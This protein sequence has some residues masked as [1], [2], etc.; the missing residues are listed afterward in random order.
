V[1]QSSQEISLDAHNPVFY[2]T[3]QKQVDFDREMSPPQKRKIQRGNSYGEHKVI[4]PGYVETFA[5]KKAQFEKDLLQKQ[6]HVEQD[7]KD[8]NNYGTHY[9][10]QPPLYPDNQVISHYSDYESAP[11]EFKSYPQQSSWESKETEKNQN[12][13]YDN[14]SKSISPAKEDNP[15]LLKKN[16]K[17]LSF[18]NINSSE[19]LSAKKYK[20]TSN[21]MNS[22][23]KNRN[24]NNIPLNQHHQESALR[25]LNPKVSKNIS[26]NTK[27]KGPN[28][29]MR[30]MKKRNSRAG[31]KRSGAMEGHRQIPTKRR[32]K[33]G[34]TFQEEVGM[35]RSQRNHHNKIPNYMLNVKKK[36]STIGSE[37]RKVGSY[38]MKNPSKM[39]EDHNFNKFSSKLPRTS[40][41]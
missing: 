9:I 21:I 16:S 22:N 35:G 20:K 39:E 2:S 12:V 17:Q 1:K 38:T 23:T 8:L 33:K 29:P 30:V 19:N 40:K 11:K 5:F 4:P 14:P 41:L 28:E 18:S 7:P 34:N 32:V 31:K 6:F 25:K 37:S 10:N 13:F 3:I 27:G 15:K 24:K 26:K 36:S